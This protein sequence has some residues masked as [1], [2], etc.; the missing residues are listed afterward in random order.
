MCGI[1]S[2]FDVGAGVCFKCVFGNCESELDSGSDL[3]HRLD[4]L[5]CYGYCDGPFCPP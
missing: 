5:N 1:K 2:G 4:R 3:T